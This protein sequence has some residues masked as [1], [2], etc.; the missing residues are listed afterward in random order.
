[1]IHVLIAVLLVGQVF[2]CSGYLV[3]AEE[4]K[5]DGPQAAGGQSAVVSV[6]TPGTNGSITAAEKWRSSPMAQLMFYANN[7]LGRQFNVTS[8]NG[9]ITDSPEGALYMATVLGAAGKAGGTCIGTVEVSA[10]C[11]ATISGKDIRD[12]LQLQNQK[13]TPSVS[14]LMND[15]NLDQTTREKLT[16]AINHPVTPIVIANGSNCGVYTMTVTATEVK[17]T[18]AAPQGNDTY[19]LTFGGGGTK[20]LVSTPLNNM[21]P[22]SSN[23]P[24][25]KIETS[26]GSNTTF[27]WGD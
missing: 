11:T 27:S 12:A 20:T 23:D 16:E 13:N 21:T 9:V 22:V 5:K 25:G 10:P 26:E 6:V 24:G 2:L 18:E 7:G 1:M 3:K 8:G 14:S 4:P 15:T 17:L 19:L